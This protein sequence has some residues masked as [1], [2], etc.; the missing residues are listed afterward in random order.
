MT[1]LKLSA[2]PDDKPVKVTVELPAAVFRDLQAYAA[3]LAKVAGEALPPEPVK[4]IAPMIARFMETD[5]GFA[6]A[7]RGHSDNLSGLYI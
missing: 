4:L 1:K 3:I 6:K 7:K 2:I 5:R